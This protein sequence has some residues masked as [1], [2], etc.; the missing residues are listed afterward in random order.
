MHVHHS[1]AAYESFERD[2]N[3][4]VPLWRHCYSCGVDFPVLRDYEHFVNIYIL[5]VCHHTHLLKRVL[6]E[7][8]SRYGDL[9]V[10]GQR[11]GLRRERRNS[12][13]C[14]N[15]LMLNDKNVALAQ[16]LKNSHDTRSGTGDI[17]T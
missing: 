8:L 7:S 6:K 12:K 13:P 1:S 5:G 16:D 11:V 10:T 17:S 2:S 4:I 9:H 14:I 3:D 15:L